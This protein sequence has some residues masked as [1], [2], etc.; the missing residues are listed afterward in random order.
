M[1]QATTILEFVTVSQPNQSWYDTINKSLQEHHYQEW[2]KKDLAFIPLED[3]LGVVRRK[4]FQIVSICWKITKMWLVEQGT[5]GAY[6][7]T[8]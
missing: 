6:C 4:R 5:D 1:L 8:Q 2:N 3:S 7:E